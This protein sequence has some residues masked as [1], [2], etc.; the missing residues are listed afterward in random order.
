[1]LAEL[2]ADDG[3]RDLVPLFLSLYSGS[4]NLFYAE[5]AMLLSREGSQ[6]GCPL[7]TLLFVLSTAAAVEAE[8]AA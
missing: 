4:S 3:L 2:Y 1:M 8:I 7:G 5:V 6:Q